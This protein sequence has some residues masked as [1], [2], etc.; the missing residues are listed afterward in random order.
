MILCTVA[1]ARGLLPELVCCAA[2][3]KRACVF[4]HDLC[5]ADKLK[6][7]GYLRLISDLSGSSDDTRDATYKNNKPLQT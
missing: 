3:R 5:V 2:H 7:N 4:K 1:I 6:V